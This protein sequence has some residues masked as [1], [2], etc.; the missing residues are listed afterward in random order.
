MA[1]ETSN[2]ATL[3]PGASILAEHK[4]HQSDSNTKR[5]AFEILRKSY[6]HMNDTILPGRF[7][8]LHM[9]ILNL[10]LQQQNKQ[11]VKALRLD[12]VLLPLSVKEEV[13]RL[14]KFMM[15]VSLDTTLVLD[16]NVSCFVQVI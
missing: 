9:A 4:F 5:Q 13:H 6:S 1:T 15:A 3:S 2:K 14:L 7:F 11:A 8:D 10:I 12:M 16:P